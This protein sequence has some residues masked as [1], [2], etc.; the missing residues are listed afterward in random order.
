MD[1]GNYDKEKMAYLDRLESN[2]IEKSPIKAELEVKILQIMLWNEIIHC[3][4]LQTKLDRI[5][6]TL[7]VFFVRCVV[8][9]FL[10]QIGSLGN[11]SLCLTWQN[12]FV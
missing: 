9:N 2:V 1:I 6:Y 10:G 3:S 8:D 7:D 11:Q 4:S 5:E 12:F